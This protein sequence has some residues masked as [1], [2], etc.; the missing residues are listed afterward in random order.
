M[1]INFEPPWKVWQHLVSHMKENINW[2]CVCSLVCAACAGR[3]GCGAFSFSRVGFRARPFSHLVVP[4]A[5][6]EIIDVVP[7]G[8]W[9][10][11]CLL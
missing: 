2:V 3:F 8:I 1:F 6:I 9:S 11:I 7:T 5:S 4:S 10:V